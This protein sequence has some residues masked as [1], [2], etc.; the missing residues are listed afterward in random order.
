[1]SVI[2]IDKLFIVRHS[3]SAR[4]MPIATRLKITAACASMALFWSSAPL[5]GWSAYTMED[6]LTSC[7]VDWSDRTLSVTSYNL[8]IFVFVFFI[9][10]LV[11]VFFNVKFVVFLDKF[12]K[13][14]VLMIR[15]VVSV[16][17]QTVDHTS[18]MMS[19]RRT[20]SVVIYIS[21]QKT[22]L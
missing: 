16:Y 2:S 20:V 3:F 11:I 17:H 14:R 8:A 22:Q 21:I 12:H 4:V 18:Q 10:L 7:A 19:F 5:A 15:A 1:M 6:A 9:P 13:R